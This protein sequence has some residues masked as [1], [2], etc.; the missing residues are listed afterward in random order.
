MQIW[1][2]YNIKSLLTDHLYL[3]A[4]LRG[5]KSMPMIVWENLVKSQVQEIVDFNISTQFWISTDKT[6]EVN[7]FNFE[8]SPIFM[9]LVPQLYSRPCPSIKHKSFPS[10]KLL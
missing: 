10:L 2:K 8:F 6:L 1:M 4:F 9:S 5:E 3:A 7:H